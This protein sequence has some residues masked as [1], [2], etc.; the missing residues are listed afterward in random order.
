M[1][2]WEDLKDAFLLSG[3]L[4]LTSVSM[5]L[6]ILCTSFILFVCFFYFTRQVCPVEIRKLKVDPARGC[7]RVKKR[8][9][10]KSVLRVK[11]KINK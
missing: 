6:I 10:S 8:E 2:P 4:T 1:T 9:S 5:C 11:N 7:S 3:Q